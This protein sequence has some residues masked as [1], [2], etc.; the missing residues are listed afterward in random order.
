MTE[1]RSSGEI[2]RRSFFRYMGAGAVAGGLPFFNCTSSKVGE[3]P[4]GKAAQT[5][6]VAADGKPNWTE[7]ARPVPSAAAPKQAPPSVFTVSDGLELAEGFSYRIIAGWGD[8]LGADGHQIRFGYNN[9]YTGLLPVP[10]SK[11]DYFLFVNHEDISARPWLQGMAKFRETAAFDVG[12]APDP[13]DPKKPVT[14]VAGT[15]VPG[16]AIPLAQI[17]ALPEPARAEIHRLCETALDD[18]G[19]SIVR[20]RRDD[21]GSFSVVRDAT[22]HR[23]FSGIAPHNVK[24][25]AGEDASS[26]D[27]PAAFLFNSAPRGTFGNCS[28]AT[29]PWGT[30]LTCEENIQNHLNPGVTP[31]GAELE[32]D[33]KGVMFQVS[34]KGDGTVDGSIPAP[35]FIYGFGFGLEKPLDGREYGWVCEFDPATGQMKKHTWLGRFRHE[36]LAPRVVA[37]KQMAAYM[38][39]DRRGGHVWKFV[40]KQKAKDAR[41]ETNLLSDG[42][43]YAARFEP[44][45]SGEWLPLVPEQ[46]LVRPQP[47]HCSRGRLTLPRRPSGGEVLVG[48]E[49]GEGVLSVDAWVAEIENYTNK[50]FDACTL[51][52]LVEGADRDQKQ[53]L[54]VLD[55]FVMANAI[56]ATPS[57]RPEDL[58][59]HPGDGSVYIAFTDHT[60]SGSG[61]PDQRIFEDAVGDV[62]RRYGGIYRLIE[63]EDDPAATRFSWG[64]FVSSGDVCDAGGGFA[65]PDNL[66][67]DPQGNLWLVTD[68]SSGTLNRGNASDK[69]AFQPGGK[70]YP[71]VFGNNAMYMV[72]ADGPSRGVPHCF[73]VGPCECELTG[74]TFAADGRTLILSVQHPGEIYGTRTRAEPAGKERFRIRNGEGQIVAQEREVPRGSNWPSDQLDTPPRP[75]VVAI[76]KG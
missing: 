62:S 47:E 10:G 69:K 70:R 27:G 14:R 45:F 6:W 15:T 17:A 39:D 59:V 73:A 57:S 32:T 23:R 44:G 40:S 13:A 66:A 43:L 48:T 50:A 4:A 75:C 9:D 3:T 72:P 22:D 26:F 53:G 61:S 29:T 28:G 74:P 38:G 21:S 11:T 42:T 58:E 65:C 76:I 8:L 2:S 56:G 35:N 31:A 37:G 68:V 34:R 16:N 20:V 60:G 18:L 52:D 30:F 64:K 67:F 41:G 19:I 36:N 49:P 5:G 54:L 71:G 24:T 51:G 7:P 55:A 12:L 1:S 33:R 46:K 25:M 63:A